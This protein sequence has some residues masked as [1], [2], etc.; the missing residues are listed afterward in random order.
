M[1]PQRSLLL[2]SLTL[3]FEVQAQAQSDA[4]TESERRHVPPDP[5]AHT[6][7]DMSN[8]RMNELM[9]MDDAANF[10]MVQL[11]QLEW[12]RLQGE[13]VATVE[14]DA[15][16]GGDYDKAWFKA[17]GEIVRGDYEGRTELLWDHVFDRW[18]TWQVGVRQ[19]FGEGPARSWLAF[20]VQGLAPYWFEIE[21]TA[22]VGDAGRTALRFSG[23]YEW[24]LTQRLVL[25][26]EVD[27]DVFG[28]DDAANGIGAGLAETELSL[29]LRYEVRRELAPYVGVVWSRQYGTTASFSR[30][31]GADPDEVYFTAGVRLW[32]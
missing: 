26:P 1:S 12:S 25:Q 2:L 9:Q 3:A 7:Q 14:A 10:G 13:D 11:E 30:D 20:G 15:W 21:A 19:D 29:R 23:E 6:M 27:V 31:E 32:F 28:K 4:R 8:E 16:Y 5:P 17:E 24:F 22:Y 18:F